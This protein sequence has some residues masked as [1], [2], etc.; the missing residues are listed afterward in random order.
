MLNMLSQ[1]LRIFLCTQPTDMRKNFN[2]LT[3]LV[4]KAMTLDP[5]SGHLFIFRNQRGD[6]L[7][8]LYWD[9]D[10]LAIWYKQLQ[11]GTFRFPDLKNYSSAGLEIDHSTLRLILDGIDLSSIRRQHRFRI[12]PNMTMPQPQNTQSISGAYKPQEQNFLA[13][14]HNA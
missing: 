4:K 13:A 7:K 14:N 10:G 6:R 11:R 12:N 1:Q 2:G 8:A 3:G 5:L 9:G